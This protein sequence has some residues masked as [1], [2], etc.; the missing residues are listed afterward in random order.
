MGSLIKT[1]ISDRDPSLIEKVKMVI[2]RGGIIALP[3]DT[4]YGLGADP[5]N[6]AAIE[7]IYQIKGRGPKKPIL[8][9]IEAIKRL[10]SLVQEVTKD[11]EILITELWPGPLTIIFKASPALPHILTGGTG[12]I[13]VRLPASSFLIWLLKGLAMPLT[14]TSANP[15]GLPPPATA[16]EIEVY[17]GGRIDLVIDAGRTDGIKVSTVI[18]ATATPMRLIRQGMVK[19]EKIEGLI[20]KIKREE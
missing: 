12:K 18:D 19:I 15:S 1:N 4:F 7:K 20:G 14:A 13:G 3:T 9:L 11:A 6:P 8:I 16:E 2:E 10:D 5:F 17:F